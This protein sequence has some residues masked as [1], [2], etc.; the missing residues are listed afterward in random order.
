ME[1]ESLFNRNDLTIEQLDRTSELMDQA[2]PGALV[3]EYEYLIE[4]LDL[5]D[6]DDC[7]V[8]AAAIFIPVYSMNNNV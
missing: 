6:P 2:I 4:G 3:A 1:A 8:L 7:H 5:P